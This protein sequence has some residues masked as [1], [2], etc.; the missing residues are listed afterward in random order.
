MVAIIPGR[1]S[2]ARLPGKIL[3]PVGGRPMIEWTLRTC[4][5]VGGMDEVV[6]ATSTD[7]SDDPVADW[8]ETAGVPCSRG[9]LADVYGRIAKT[10]REHPSDVFFRVNADSPLVNRHL[11]DEALAWHR[12]EELDLVTNIMPRTFPPGVSIEAI[13][14]ATYLGIG[15]DL[16]AEDREHVTRRFYQH[17]ADYRIRN[18]ES[19]VDFSGIHLAIDTEVD[20]R[21]VEQLLGILGDRPGDV[22]FSELASAVA[23]LDPGFPDA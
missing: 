11:F 8:C 12:A 1:M 9:D 16:D 4:Q 7:E 6:V 3:R 22:S 10:C 21:R 17:R 20:H 15:W 19:S 5:S 14:T 13:R 23:S 18:L 2:S